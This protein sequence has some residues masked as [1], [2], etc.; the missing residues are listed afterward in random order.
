MYLNLKF[1]LSGLEQTWIKGN[2]SINLPKAKPSK[3]ALFVEWRFLCLEGLE[4]NFSR[5]K[6]LLGC[7]FLF[8]DSFQ[9]HGYMFLWVDVRKTFVLLWFWACKQKY[10]IIYQ[11]EMGFEKWIFYVSAGRLSIYKE[12]S[13]AISET[14]DSS[15][16]YR[17]LNVQS[18]LIKMLYLLIE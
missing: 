4:I 1:F 13:F 17:I 3:T 11:S 12:I 2:S 10:F 8:G 18:I 5:S 16:F 7:L 14:S 15:R 9:S 6:P